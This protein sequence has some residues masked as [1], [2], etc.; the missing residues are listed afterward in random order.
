MEVDIDHRS[1]AN[2]VNFDETALGFQSIGH[3]SSIHWARKKVKSQVKLSGIVK[4]SAFTT[5]VTEYRKMWQ[6]GK[7]GGHQVIFVCWRKILISLRRRLI[8]SGQ[9]CP[10]VECHELKTLRNMRGYV[11]AFWFVR[12]TLLIERSGFEGRGHCIVF[13]GKTLYSHSASLHPGV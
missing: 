8:T 2:N 3:I 11:V 7:C 12:C 4:N 10:S 6:R 5:T 9:L 1:S 13:L